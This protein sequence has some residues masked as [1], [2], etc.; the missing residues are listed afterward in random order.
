MLADFGIRAAGVCGMFSADNDLSSNRG[1][2]RQAAVDYIR[3]EA[4]FCR[5]IGAEYLLVCPAAVGRPQKYD[6]S[7]IERSLDTLRIAADALVEAG[8]KGA[9][10][11]IRS[12]E[13]T[14]IHTVAQAKEYIRRL[15]HPGV[16]HINGDVYHMLSE[17]V[18]VPSA[19][20]DAGDM[21]VNPAPGRLEPQG[22]GDGCLNIDDIIRAL[23]L[24]GYDDEHHFATP[25]PLGPGGDPYR[26]STR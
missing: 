19:V 4:E 11:P 1:I 22:A 17:E 15:N 14:I 8:V 26:R 23:Y 18:N 3:R 9:I 16:R 2:Q 21:L 12:A 13:T 7:E 5:E 24:I 6:D 10:E 20:Y 25:E